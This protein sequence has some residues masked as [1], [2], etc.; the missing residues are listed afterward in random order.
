MK[1][2]Y[3]MDTFFTN[4]RD[5]FP[6]ILHYSTNPP[7]FHKSSIIPQI[8]HFSTNP[9]FFHKSSIIPQI[10]HYSTNPPL[11]HKFSIIPQILH[12]STNPTLFHKSS[13]I[14]TL[15]FTFAWDAVCRSSKT[16]S[17]N[18]AALHA[19]CVSARRRPQNGVTGVY[20]SGDQQDGSRRVLNRD[21][22]GVWGEHCTSVLH[23][24]T[25]CADRCAVWHCHAGGWVDPT[26]CVAEPFRIRC[27]HLFNL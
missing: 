13:I 2:A 6:Q 3:I 18:V 14:H 26:F 20:P 8:L 16:L 21:C 23:L 10:L 1:F 25:L 27:V 5:I 9:P 4:L 19:T 17:W 24:P 11:F 22:R 7:L 12:Y 15:F